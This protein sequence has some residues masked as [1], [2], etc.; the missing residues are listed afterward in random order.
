[1]KIDHDTVNVLKSFS[2]INPSILI[3]EGN[4]L[5]TISA[6]KTIMAKATVP[7][8]FTNRFAIY[9]LDQFLANLSLYKD[10]ELKFA[11]KRVDIK[12]DRRKGHFFYSDENTITKAPEKDIALP[13]ADV[14]FTL[15]NADLSEVEKAAG[16]LQV[17]EVA[18]VGDGK[19]ISLIAT[20]SK[21]PTSNDWSVDIGVTDKVFKAIFKVDN[22]RII[23][24]EYEV[25]ISSKGI[26]HFV[27][28]DNEVEY[29]I[30]VEQNSQF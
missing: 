20:D 3:Q 1:M 30:A 29:F 27:G 23:P 22:I 21:N 5:K 16:V 7:T 8:K 26:S 6:S 11:D 28:K 15:T 19:T 10:P 2:K 17:P 13:S 18:V 14:S 25:T 9:S 4:T 12:D 24:G